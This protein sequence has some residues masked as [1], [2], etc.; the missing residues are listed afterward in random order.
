M[1]LVYDR[2]CFTQRR[3]EAAKTQRKPVLCDFAPSLRL[4]VKPI[5]TFDF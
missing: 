5:L 4:C 3:K 2:I 1:K